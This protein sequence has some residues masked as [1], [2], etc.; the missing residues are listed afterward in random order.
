[1]M[2]CPRVNFYFFVLGCCLSGQEM[3][4]CRLTQRVVVSVQDQ[5]RETDTAHALV[6]ALKTSEEGHPQSELDSTGP[7]ELVSCEPGLDLGVGGDLLHPDPPH[8]HFW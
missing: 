4:S 1:M 3:R 8:L 5:E 2:T 7:P 6:D